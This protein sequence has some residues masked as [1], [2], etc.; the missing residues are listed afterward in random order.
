MVE[1]WGESRSTIRRMIQPT[2]WSTA[3]AAAGKFL[4]KGTRQS[5]IQ[6][7]QGAP[8][9]QGK[10][11]QPVAPSKTRLDSLVALRD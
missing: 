2:Q 8:L 1:L 10:S 9:C 6:T 7:K 5:K 4:A 3:G 11:W